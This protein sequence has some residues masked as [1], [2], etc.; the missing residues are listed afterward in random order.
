MIRIE[1][2]YG[3]TTISEQS[4]LSTEWNGSLN[5]DKNH[6]PIG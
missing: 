1:S 5:W 2:Q 4:Q 3:N 6:A